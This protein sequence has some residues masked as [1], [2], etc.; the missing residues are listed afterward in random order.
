MTVDFMVVKS[1]LASH[2]TGYTARVKTKQTISF[3]Q[4]TD[5]VAHRRTT[6]AKSDVLSVLEDYHQIIEK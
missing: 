2:P 5:M 4:V 1:P 3:D 6:V